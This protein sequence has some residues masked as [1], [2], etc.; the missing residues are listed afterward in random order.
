MYNGKRFA[1]VFNVGGCKRVV[2][3]AGACFMD[4]ELGPVVR[5]SL[6]HADG[7]CTSGRETL[8][9]QEEALR[10]RLVPDDRYGCDFQVDLCTA[11]S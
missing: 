1:L 3:G 5:V 2:S 4:R 6:Q 8:V 7:S 11:E 10:Q 9:L